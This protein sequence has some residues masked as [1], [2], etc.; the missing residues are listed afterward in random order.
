MFPL[1]ENEDQNLDIESP[2]ARSLDWKCHGSL[3]GGHLKYAH[4]GKTIRFPFRGTAE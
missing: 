2:S 4:H 1:G 3:G